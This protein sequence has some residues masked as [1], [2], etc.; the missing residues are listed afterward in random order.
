MSGVL[1]LSD[2]DGCWDDVFD[3]ATRVDLRVDNDRLLA[4]S[5]VRFDDGTP[6]PDAH[7]TIE[8]SR[9]SADERQL[10]FTASFSNATRLLVA[11]FAASNQSLVGVQR[12]LGT[13]LNAPATAAGADVAISLRRPMP[14]FVGPCPRLSTNGDLVG[15]SLVEQ[16]ILFV[17]GTVFLLAL[18]ALAVLLRRSQRRRLERLRQAAMI[19]DAESARQMTGDNMIALEGDE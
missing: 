9:F 19:S 18:L 13:A 17:V 11:L 5:R 7:L 10:N 15:A 8:S 4:F 1:R 16:W 3:N 12:V 6:Y 14:P 2:F